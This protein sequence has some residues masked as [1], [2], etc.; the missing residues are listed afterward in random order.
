MKMGGAHGKSR[1]VAPVDMLQHRPMESVVLIADTVTRKLCE[2]PFKNLSWSQYFDQ[3]LYRFIES[4]SQ[5]PCGVIAI[6]RKSIL[7]VVLSSGDRVLLYS[8]LL[9][10][11]QNIDH[12]NPCK[13]SHMTHQSCRS[14]G[15]WEGSDF[16]IV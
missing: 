16:P 14:R 13:T 15:G 12:R 4:I 7:Q 9:P 5:S 6:G 1:E 11:L 3:T 2:R 10:I 8:K